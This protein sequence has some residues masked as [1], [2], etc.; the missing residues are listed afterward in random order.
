[1][2]VRKEICEATINCLTK[3]GYA[4]TSL[5]RVAKTAGFSKGAL[6]HHF[7]TK[8]DLMVATA[9]RLLERPFIKRRKTENRPTSVEDEIMLQWHK[10]TN[11]DAYL[12][13]LEILIATRT[14]QKLQDRIKNKLAD[15][16]DALDQHAL[17]TFEP[18]QG[19][20]E[21]VVAIATMTRS[22]MRGLVIQDRYSHDPEKTLDLI[23]RWIAFIE[24]ELALRSC[25]P[26]ESSN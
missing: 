9:D 14:D 23:H 7:P 15:W 1:M 6:Q 26:E 18:I 21:D 2:R 16:N 22:L 12:A 4:E 5:Q 17:S 13:L 24:P 3:V 25:D 20:N 8:E 10:L 19:T 11:T